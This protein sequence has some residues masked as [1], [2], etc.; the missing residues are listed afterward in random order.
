MVQS[1]EFKSVQNEFLNKLQEDV[2]NICSSK[3]ILVIA[4]K[5]TNLYEMSQGHFFYYFHE[6]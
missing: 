2:E 5:S 6:P 3:N 1:I 4:D